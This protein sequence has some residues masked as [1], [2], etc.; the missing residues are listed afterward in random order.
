MEVTIFDV[1]F[2][3]PVSLS[4]AATV[5]C[6]SLHLTA[7]RSGTPASTRRLLVGGGVMS[8]VLPAVAS[9]ALLRTSCN[10]DTGIGGG[11]RAPWV[12]LVA[13]VIAGIG[14]FRW[15]RVVSGPPESR[16]RLPA[17]LVGISVVGFVVES[18]VG[19]VALSGVCEFDEPAYLFLQGGLALLIPVVAVPL[20]L[21]TRRPVGKPREA[22]RAW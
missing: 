5:A 20:A 22:D 3:W 15:L 10:P 13:L 11:L 9:R 7:M 18:V 12:F 2:L 17:I 21:S 14:A 19:L 6:L 1:W 8:F 16:W 4:A